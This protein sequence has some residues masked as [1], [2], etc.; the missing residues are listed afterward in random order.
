MDIGKNFTFITE[1]EA[2]IKKVGI[3]AACNL[4]IIQFVGVFAF[5][6]YAKKMFKNVQ[7]G[8]EK[9]LPE[10]DDFVA[11]I[12]EGLKGAA[13]MLGW[14]VPGIILYVISFALNMGA[15]MGNS[16]SLQMA[17]AACGC[18]SFLVIM[19]LQLFLVVGVMRFFATDSIGEG[20][21][22][23]AIIGFIKANVGQYLLACVMAFVTMLA[24]MVVGIIACG[25]GIFVTLPYAQ[26]VIWK[27]FADVYRNASQAAVSM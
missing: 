18:I 23:G 19:A 3:A 2:W 27:N 24:A 21:N 26:L 17:G 4:P 6:G 20:F 8:H 25:V 10:W 16:S 11:Y 5:L 15:A 9:P 14:M 22:F 12:V 13:V 7:E 1:D